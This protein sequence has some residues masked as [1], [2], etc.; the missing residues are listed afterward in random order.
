MQLIYLDFQ[1]VKSQLV[2]QHENEKEKKRKDR[3]LTRK[4]QC[5]NHIMIIS[6]ISLELLLWHNGLGS[7]SGAL[8]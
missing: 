6:T 5:M 1:K 3:E 7:V 4:H 2:G 8:G